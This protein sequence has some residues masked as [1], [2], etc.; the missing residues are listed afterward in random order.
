MKVDNKVTAKLNEQEKQELYK[1]AR[2]KAWY[3]GIWQTVGKCVFCDLRDKYIIHEEHGIVL[4]VNIYPYI[5]GQMLAVP[6][7]H[8]KSP[9]ELTER[10][11]ETMRKFS[12]IAKK[13]IRKTHGHKGMW[14]LLRE[15]GINAQMSVSDHLHMQFIPFDNSDLATWNYRE[16]KHTPLENAG[17]Y[18]ENF[19]VIQ[20]NAIKFDEKYS[21]G[22][23]LNLI[24]DCIFK[25]E[26][27]EA[28]LI[29]RC[30]DH[31]IEGYDYCFPGGHLDHVDQGVFGSLFDEMKE[32][33]NYS[34]KEESVKLLDSRL[35]KI[36]YLNDSKYLGVEM[37]NSENVLW[38]IYYYDKVV[39]SSEFK[40]GDDA[41]SL[42]WIK[43]DEVDK[44]KGISKET[45]EILHKFFSL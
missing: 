38:N 25:N 8:I 2:A 10:Q 1:N 13:L 23:L 16:L 9:K 21:S 11:W 29:K 31:K 26:K 39:N 28:L 40:A 35:S 43:E 30:E 15:G 36:T 17:L 37:K 34:I 27:G 19:K 24:T 4:T 20:K 22:Q 7:N 3:D 42:Y 44:F 12:Y 18:K 41:D 32:E 14:S 45:K 5:D 33:V 6:R